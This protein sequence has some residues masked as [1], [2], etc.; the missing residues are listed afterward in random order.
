MVFRKAEEMGRSHPELRTES[1]FHQLFVCLTIQVPSAGPSTAERS[2][3]LS[4]ETTVT[5]RPKNLF[6]KNV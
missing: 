1:P 4:L 3:T 5:G 2:E 6:S